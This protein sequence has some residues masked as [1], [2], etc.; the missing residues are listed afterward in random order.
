MNDQNQNI[1]ILLKEARERQGMTI[2]MVHE[3]TKIPMDSLKAIEEGY[4]V[5]TLSPFYYKSFVKIYAQLVGLDPYELLA[6]ISSTPSVSEHLVKKETSQQQKEMEHH[7][8]QKLLNIAN[9]FSSKY[10]DK[11]LK[12]S[13]LV[14]GAG[15]LLSAIIWGGVKIVRYFSSRPAVVKETDKA[16]QSIKKTASSPSS[17]STNVAGSSK[18]TTTIEKKVVVTVR[19]RINAWF[20]VRV[21]GK[22]VF[23]QILKKGGFE[24]WKADER[25]EISGDV[26]S[27]ELEVNGEVKKLARRT[28][29]IRKVVITPEGLSVEK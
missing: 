16:P 12:I 26:E 5:R 23:R 2:E 3:V 4:K 22:V 14:L 24:T 19:A 15:F 21:D 1:G 9:S 27:L 17:V 6:K 25:I 10:R 8:E 20:I 28:T 13:V 7:Q 18:T 11:I 29:Q